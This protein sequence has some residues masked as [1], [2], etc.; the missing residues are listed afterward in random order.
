MAVYK[1]SYK[2]YEGRLTAD[3]SRFLVPSRY[4]LETLFQSRLLVGCMVAS[5]IFPL[6][7]ATVIY[8]HHNLT[9][10]TMLRIKPDNLLPIDGD[11]FGA[12]FSFQGPLLSC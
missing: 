6:F 2:P 7:G 3:W 9:A 11:F 5:C 12:F 10:L 8:L 4:A 1:R